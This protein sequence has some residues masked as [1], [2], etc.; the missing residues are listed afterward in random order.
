MSSVAYQETSNNFTIGD[1]K[2]LNRDIASLIYGPNTPAE[3]GV[4]PSRVGE[5]YVQIPEGAEDHKVHLW[6]SIANTPT[7]T[8]HPLEVNAALPED[9]VRKN[10]AN[11]FN[12]VSQTIGTHQIVTVIVG[13]SGSVPS[14]APDFDGQIFFSFKDEG[15]PEAKGAAW[16]A[17]GNQWLPIASG[18]IVDD[19][20]AK[21]DVTN[22]FKMV[23]KVG[24]GQQIANMVSGR[25]TSYDPLDAA[26]PDFLPHSAG[27]ILTRN[28]ID[29]EGNAANQVYMAIIAGDT[30][31]WELIYDDKLSLTALES[32]IVRIDGNVDALSEKVNLE[33][34]DMDRLATTVADI[35]LAQTGIEGDIS[36]L[37]TKLNNLEPRVLANESKIAAL[38]TAVFPPYR[39]THSED[40]LLVRIEELERKVELLT[41]LIK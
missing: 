4:V 13:E 16:M 31:S 3:A 38:E 2:I 24:E 28:Y 8:W 23:Q 11:D 40:E 1:Q 9:I 17:K 30:D 27:D 34:E 12:N 41:S 35:D 36:L 26:S 20:L 19:N 39:Y 33:I 29:T 7:P 14:S 18:E 22:T 6:V 15:T 37:G 5:V 10:Q 21:L 32:E 25:R